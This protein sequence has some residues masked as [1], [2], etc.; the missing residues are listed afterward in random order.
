AEL[1]PFPEPTMLAADER[2]REYWKATRGMQGTGFWVV[3]D[4]IARLIGK[5]AATAG[6]AVPVLLYGEKKTSVVAWLKV[7]LIHDGGSGFRPDPSF[8]GLTALDEGE[9]S[10][11]QAMQ[12]SWRLSGV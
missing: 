11:H 10:F 6:A 8:L 7:E 12:R 3:W 2:F 5:R 4:L 9:E 1:P